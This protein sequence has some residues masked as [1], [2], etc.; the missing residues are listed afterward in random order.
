VDVGAVPLCPITGT[1]ARR[2]IQPVSASLLIG[3]WR[4]CFGVDAS[5][6]LA[7]VRRFGLWES[8]CGLAFF[9]PMRAGDAAFY[10]RLYRRLKLHRVLAGPLVDRPEFV[11]AAELVRDGDRV[12]DVGGG[13]G[14]FSRYV[15][16][17]VYVG[18]EPNEAAASAPAEMRRE[19][20]AE[21]ARAHP[22]CYD[23]VCAFQ[24]IEHVVEP[25]RF[26]ESLVACLRPGGRLIVGV[27]RRGS[28]ITEIPN[29]A[30]NAPPHHLTW[31]TQEALG[32]LAAKCGLAVEFAEPVRL[33]SHDSI[34][35][36]MGRLAPR[37]GG[38]FFRAHWRWYLGFVW[39]WLAGRVADAC[40]KVPAG[41]EPVVLV[42]AA[43]KA[44]AGG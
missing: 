24:V 42:M 35:Y 9:E 31:W 40:R 14:G 13:E 8:E 20:L 25:L 32:A 7:G 4:F 21:H 39:C 12:L 19:S 17:A 33:G 27:P 36:W 6:L 41:A 15:P 28:G 43:R 26:A 34:L 38:R 10:D 30:F 18:L 22:A 3:L 5:G 23:V 29:F 16:H 2:L 37:L 1:P 11:R 44:G